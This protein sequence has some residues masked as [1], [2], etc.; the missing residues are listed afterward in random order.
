MPLNRKQLIWCMTVGSVCRESSLVRCIEVLLQ[1]KQ[2]QKYTQSFRVSLQ[3]KDR[4]LTTPYW[5][6]WFRETL[7]CIVDGRVPRPFAWPKR[8][9]PIEPTVQASR[10]RSSMFPSTA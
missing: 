3:S 10:S 2:R 4:E 9:L 7:D 8:W 6:C 1:E 5:T